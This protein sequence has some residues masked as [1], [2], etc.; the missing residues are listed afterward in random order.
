MDYA[1]F[2]VLGI[3]LLMD[4]VGVKLNDARVRDSS[5]SCKLLVQVWFSDCFILVFGYLL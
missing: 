5:W 2:M 3:I 1:I 4:Y